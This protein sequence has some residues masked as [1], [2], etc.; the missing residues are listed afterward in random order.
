MKGLFVKDLCLMATQKRFF[1]LILGVGAL[2]TFGGQDII[3]VMGYMMMVFGLFSGST[4]SYDD[5]NGL[6]D[7]AACQQKAVC[8]E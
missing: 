1:I 6:S 2:L 8:E 5:M 7:D 4:I 3:F